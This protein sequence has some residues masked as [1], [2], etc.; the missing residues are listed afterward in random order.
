MNRRIFDNIKSPACGR[1]NVK[2]FTGDGKSEQH[3]QGARL[4][5]GRY[6]GYSKSKNPSK[7]DGK[8]PR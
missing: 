4:K 7:S 6:D 1:R 3:K 2:I 8:M 5:G